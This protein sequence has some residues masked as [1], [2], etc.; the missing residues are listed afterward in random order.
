MRQLGRQCLRYVTNDL[1]PSRTC[2]F[3]GEEC[4]LQ[5]TDWW[6]DWSATERVDVQAYLISQYAEH[7]LNHVVDDVDTE[8]R[9]N[10]GE[11]RL[12]K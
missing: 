6:E 2:S 12:K 4:I 10:S 7:V 1:L 8:Q 5:V 11:G 3:C 9:M